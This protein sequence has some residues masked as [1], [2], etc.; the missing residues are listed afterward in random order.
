M[1]AVSGDGL[2][3]LLCCHLAASRRSRE[4]AGC[5][6]DRV[7]PYVWR[8]SRR[9]QTAGSTRYTRTASRLKK[10]TERR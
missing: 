9:A 10:E 7:L 3:E 5:C 4:A 6:F 2:P 8:G 1:L